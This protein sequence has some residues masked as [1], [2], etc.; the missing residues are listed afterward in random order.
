M[1]MGKVLGGGSSNVMVWARG[2]RTDWDYFVAE[3]GDAGWSYESVLALYRRIED[4]GGAPDPAYRG[5]FLSALRATPMNVTTN[6]S[7][8]RVRREAALRQANIA[9]GFHNL[10]DGQRLAAT[11]KLDVIDPATG[12]ILAKVPDVERSD[13][14][15][16]VEAAAR[17]LPSWSRTPWNVRKAAVGRMIEALGEHVEELAT[18]LAA[19][20][21]LSMGVARWEIKWITELDFLGFRRNDPYQA[22]LAALRED[23]RAW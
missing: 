5:S 10:V 9:A 17:A 20:G 14:D 6:T 21:G 11:E 4:W 22:A 12:E 2:H 7:S 1:S 15:A 19:E 8:V 3:A 23:T 13:L 18:L 16:A